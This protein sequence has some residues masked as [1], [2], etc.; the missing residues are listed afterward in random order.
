MSSDKSEVDIATEP[1][2]LA[3]SIK[4]KNINVII[5]GLVRRGENLE[6]KRIKTNTIIK[7]MYDEENMKY[8][9]HNNNK[10]EDP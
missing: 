5:S 9:E 2:T 7:D 3:H 4:A 6:S 1:L 10:I 8:I